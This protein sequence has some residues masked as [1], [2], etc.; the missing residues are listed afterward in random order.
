MNTFFSR[1]IKW[2]LLW[3]LV[4][5]HASIIIGWIAYYNYQPKLLIQYHYEDYKF[6]LLIAQGV[7]LFITPPIAGWLGDRYRQK[8]GNRLPIIVM[9]IS[10]AAMVFMT[11]AFTIITNPPESFLWLLP[12]MIV[13]WLISMSIFTSPA[14]S[15][16]E[17]FAPSGKM[18]T[19]VAILSIVSGLLY[20]LEPVIVDIIDFWG[21]AFTFFAG[22]ALVLISGYSLRK[23]IT[24]S[25]IVDTINE[26]IVDTI[27]WSGYGKIFVTGL[28]FG[29]V[30]AIIFN[31]FPELIDQKINN[32]LGM[33][34]SGKAWISI[35]L[36][37]SA[38]FCLPASIWV[39]R[40]G[41]TKS[42]RLGFILCFLIISFLL[43]TTNP[44]VMTVLLFVFAIA[45]SVLSVSALPLA[46]TQSG[47]KHKVMAIGIFFS[48][49]ELP[50]TVMDILMY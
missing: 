19:V 41:L 13:L 25:T 31:I 49:V 30:T 29:L 35:I 44:N 32:F 3:S 4:A 10:F 16:S 5:L 22:G 17:L 46:L 20:S 34:W 48:G 9:G 47:N 18:P 23:S 1:D 45:Y 37:I 42:L 27:S 7:I 14:L 40:T 6:F 21:A 26:K 39:E 11:V 15:T 33:G 50:N 12:V 38:I 43:N 2:K 24:E 8:Q 36:A 28:A